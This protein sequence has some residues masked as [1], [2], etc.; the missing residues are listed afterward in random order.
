MDACSTTLCADTCQVSCLSVSDPR[1]SIVHVIPGTYSAGAWAASSFSLGRLP[2]KARLWYQHGLLL[3]RNLQIKPPLAE[4]IA[5]LAN[6]YLIA[7]PCGCDQTRHRWQRDRE[8][9]DVNSYDAAM[10]MSYFGTTMRGAVFAWS[11]IK[12]LAPLATGGALT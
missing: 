12:R 2:D 8:E 7:E 5:R 10:A 1:N 3:Q 9:A 4:A 11:V 6:T